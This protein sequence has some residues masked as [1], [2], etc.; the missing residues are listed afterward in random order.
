[1]L[2]GIR[3][4]RYDLNVQETHTLA[5]T[6]VM[7]IE[8]ASYTDVVKNIKFFMAQNR[9]GFKQGAI[10]EMGGFGEKEFSNMLNGRKKIQAPDIPRIAKALSI[11]PNELLCKRK[12]AS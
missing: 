9:R 3:F 8:F 7:D 6:E 1:M 2:D 11:T 10:A 12:N 4:L 5:R